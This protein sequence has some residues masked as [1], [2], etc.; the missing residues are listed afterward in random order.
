[1]WL[2]ICK[3]P[4][5]G[6]RCFVYLLT[7][8][9]WVGHRLHRHCDFSVDYLWART[10]VSQKGMVSLLSAVRRGHLEIV[11]LLLSAGADPMA[12]DLVRMRA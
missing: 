3:R 2:S 5:Q 12:S 1:M 10:M 9:L 11:R 7:C 4:R 8:T 6:W